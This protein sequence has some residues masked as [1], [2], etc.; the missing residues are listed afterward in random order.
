MPDWIGPNG[1]KKRLTIGDLSKKHSKPTECPTNDNDEHTTGENLLRHRPSEGMVGLLVGDIHRDTHTEDKEWED[2][3]G[4]CA[5]V[6]CRMAERRIDMRP[7]T[8]VI[9]KDHA[10][11]SDTTQYIQ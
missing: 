5:T 4:R 8:R 3:V 11:D 6:P 7:S 10:R 2:K 9:D 1:I